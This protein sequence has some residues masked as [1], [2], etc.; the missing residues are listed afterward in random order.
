MEPSIQRVVTQARELESEVQRVAFEALQVEGDYERSQQLLVVASDIRKL[1]IRL[2]EVI[3]GKAKPIRTGARES[4]ATSSRKSRTRAETSGK[5][6]PVIY[7]SDGRIVKIG[8]GKLKTAKEYRHEAPRSAYEVVARWIEETT[9]AG[10]REWMAKTA[11]E[12][13]SDQVP[14]YQ[15]YVV[16]AALQAVGVVRSPRRGWYSISDSAGDLDEWW[17]LLEGRCEDGASGGGS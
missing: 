9:I 10:S 13:L 6:Y 7:V 12:A 2:E 1:G 16:I 15:I 17:R 14:T 8:K 11:D 5:K 4:S 3:S